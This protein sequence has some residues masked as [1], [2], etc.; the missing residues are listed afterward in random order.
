MTED[1]LQVRCQRTGA[2]HKITEIVKWLSEK[3]EN[4]PKNNIF[5]AFIKMIF[6]ELFAVLK[7]AI[8]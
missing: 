5:F 3:K 4:D 2:E 6:F 7:I 8:F 1:I